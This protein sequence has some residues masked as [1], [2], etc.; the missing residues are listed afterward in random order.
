ML[1]C[2]K[3][4]TKYIPFGFTLINCM[5]YTSNLTETFPSRFKNYSNSMKLEEKVRLL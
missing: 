1:L 5:F 4:I 2:S 3:R